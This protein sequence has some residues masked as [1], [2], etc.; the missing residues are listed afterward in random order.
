MAAESFAGFLDKL[1]DLHEKEVYGL[2][3]KLNELTNERCRDT[4]RIEEL[5]AKNHQLRE[6]QKLLKENVKVLEN[7]LRAGLCD[8]CQVTQELAKKKQHEFGKAHFQSL[9]LIFVLTNEMNK[10]REENKNLKEDL[11][12]LWSTDYF[13]ASQ[14]ECHEMASSYESLKI[15]TKKEQL[16]LLKQHFA[17]HHLGVRNNPSSQEG[18]FLPHLLTSGDVGGRT[19]SQDEWED[20]AA[21]LD[22]PD[23]LMYVK[24]HALENRF[25]LLNHPEK[26]HFLLTEKQQRESHPG[27]Q[28]R[29]GKECK[30]ERSFLDESTHGMLG[31]LLSIHQ[32]RLE[33]GEE[34]EAV[35]E[36]LTD[37]PLDLSDSRRGR[38]SLKPGN[39]PPPSGEYDVGSPYKGQK[40]A[41]CLQ[42]ACLPSWLQEVKHLRRSKEVEEK[43][44]LK[45]KETTVL[46]PISLHQEL[47]ASCPVSCDATVGSETNVPVGAEQQRRDQA[48]K[49]KIKIIHSFR[50]KLGEVDILI[51][52]SQ[53]CWRIKTAEMGGA[54]EDDSHPGASMTEKYCCQREDTQRSQRKR[55]KG[56]DPWIEAHT[57]SARGRQNGKATQDSADA[58]E[59]AK[60]MTNHSPVFRH[61]DNEET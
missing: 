31:K 11:K 7:R 22:F 46:S 52:V 45:A 43:F 47:P 16:S 42:K 38:G 57:K 14:S 25:H 19:R 41:S 50:M 34:A 15:A 54:Y 61:S 3:T 10:L 18:S 29:I 53:G 20:P 6:Q 44:H 59:S 27:M 35:R 24:D 1:K 48:G 56:P 4:Q 12:R 21:I 9:Q 49:M 17:L 60:D 58:Q 5:F 39:W 28:E 33:Q 51:V 23:A 32:E 30:K 40:E 13:R 37:A 26:L 36:Y 8:R 2:Q 55:K